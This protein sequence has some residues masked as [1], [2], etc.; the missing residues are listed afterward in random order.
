MNFYIERVTVRDFKQFTGDFVVDNL[1]PGLNIF[2]GY[3]ES[4]KSTLVQAIRTVFLERYKTSSLDIAPDTKPSAQPS[5]EVVFHINGQQMVL[6]KQFLKS[7]RCDLKTGTE[8]LTGDEAEERLAELLGFT[9]AKTGALRAEQA[10]IP[11]LLWVRQGEAH[12]VH[13]A[14]GHAASYLRDALAQL[15]GGQVSGGEDLLISQVEKALGEFLTDKQRRPTGPLLEVMNRVTQLEKRRDELQVQRN[16]YEADLANLTT[17]QALYAEAERL[18]AWQKLEAKAL[19]AQARADEVKK[20]EQ[21]RAGLEQ[22]LALAQV[23]LSWLQDQEKAALEAE[24]LV[25]TQRRELANARTALDEA[26][27]A[28]VVAQSQVTEAQSA[29]E[30]ANKALQLAN[31]AVTAAELISQSGLLQEQ[32]TRLEKAVAAGQQASLAYQQATRDAAAAEIDQA[33]LK[34]LRSIEKDLVPLRAKKEAASTRI[35]YRLNNPVTVDGEPVTGIGVLLVESPKIIGLPGLG[36]MTITPGTS[37]IED[38]TAKLEALDAEQRQLLH[39]LAV[40]SLG[41]AEERLEHWK[42]LTAQVTTEKQRLELYAPQGLEALQ[43]ELTQASTRLASVQERVKALPDVSDAL[44]IDVAKR[45]AAQTLHQSKLA[46]A[47]LTEAAEKKS[48][49]R[50]NVESLEETL[51]R[52]EARLADPVFIAER[53][54]RQTT[55]VEKR[56]E[57]NV[58]TAQI[59]ATNRDIA[60]AAKDDPASEA[61]R[62]RT[63]AKH[64]QEEQQDRENRI[65]KLRARLEALGAQGVGE[66]LAQTEA[67][68]EQAERRKEEL[69]SHAKALELLLNLLTEERDAAV[70]E[71]RAPLTQRLEHYYKW[72][73][74]NARVKLTDNL[75]P[76]ELVRGDHANRLEVL[77]GGT[78]EQIGILT[79]L[80]YADMLADANRPT[81]VILDDATG[82]SD[83]IRLAA[84]KRALLDAATRHQIFV[85]SCEPHKWEDLGVKRRSLEDLRAAA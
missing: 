13:D 38:L 47:A 80:A 1:Q 19:E 52:H 7:P 71:L 65:L 22:T 16:D 26:D 12:Q 78:C 82:Y 69:T 56:S 73:F 54:A 66:A 20:L 3:N 18:R 4:G 64:A 75:G 55:L 79:R 15:S 10:G 48:A 32:V 27:A 76:V 5:I 33:K 6:A 30:L 40:Q 42:S 57:V 9:R 77:S 45:Q 62:L 23:E 68:L 37:N 2:T 34:R 67:E 43:A 8:H 49:G 39:A 41:E 60:V 31:D 50:L 11:G 58:L 84:L 63:S 28:Y 70:R 81:M 24:T 51:A 74:P 35:D 59:D 21:K 61:E 17:Q 53:A 46:Q 36:E 44:P 83:P 29:H 14:S 25:D 72:V 85:L